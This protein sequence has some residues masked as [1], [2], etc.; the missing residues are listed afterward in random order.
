[1]QGDEALEAGLAEKAAEFKKAGS[2]IYLDANTSTKV[3]A[4]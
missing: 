4:K 3:P 2:E 1:M